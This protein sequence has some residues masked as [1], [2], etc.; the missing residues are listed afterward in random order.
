MNACYL[1]KWCDSI[2]GRKSF[3]S[4][5]YIH[6]F[7]RKLESMLKF[8][9]S[10]RCL[11]LLCMKFQREPIRQD[12]GKQRTNRAEDE[13]WWEGSFSRG[14]KKNHFEY[15]AKSGLSFSLRSESSG[16]D[17]W[18]QRER[19]PPYL[20]SDK[21]LFYQFSSALVNTHWSLHTARWLMA[22]LN[23]FHGF[24]STLKYK[25]LLTGV[26]CGYETDSLALNRNSVWRRMRGD[27]WRQFLDRSKRKTE[28]CFPIYTFYLI[29]ILKQNE[30][31]VGVVHFWHGR[32]KKF[33]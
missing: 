4:Y 16:K 31:K 10:L 25:A 28:E 9:L 14:N 23:T 24:P 8:L 11:P 27:C 19:S 5:W 21:A 2:T 17:F 22:S 6:Y 13:A 3:R 26:L 12:I 7:G 33:V 32:H 29:L 15:S 18:I 30:C 1:V 20:T